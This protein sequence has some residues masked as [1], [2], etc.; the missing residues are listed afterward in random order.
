[1]VGDRRRTNANV[2]PLVTG[3]NQAVDG[4]A[5]GDGDADDADCISA[6]Q[7]INVLRDLALGDELYGDGKHASGLRAKAAQ[8]EEEASDS[9]CFFVDEPWDQ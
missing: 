4:G 3:M 7:A 9:G 2:F 1:M 5:T 8:I 6:A